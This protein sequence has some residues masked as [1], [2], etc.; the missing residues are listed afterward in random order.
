MYNVIL[1]VR[2]NEKTGY[3]QWVLSRSTQIADI[4]A[5]ALLQHLNLLHNYFRSPA[6]MIVFP[7]SQKPENGQILR[8]LY[9]TRP[10]LQKH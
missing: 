10:F 4:F 1:E 2:G 8:N 3:E 9:Y 5:E 6:P 7:I